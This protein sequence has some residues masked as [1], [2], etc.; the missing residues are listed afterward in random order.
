MTVAPIL[1]IPARLAAQL[2]PAD[3][4]HTRPAVLPIQSPSVR[5]VDHKLVT[6]GC[7]IRWVKRP[8]ILTAV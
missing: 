6:V 1:V 5:V 8:R 7:P 2:I 3:R 4:V